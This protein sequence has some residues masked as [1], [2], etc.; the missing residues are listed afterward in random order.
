MKIKKLTILSILTVALFTG[1]DKKEEINEN[2]VAPTAK[3]A[4]ETT[5]KSQLPTFHLTTTTGKPITIEVTKKNWV[6]KEYP[7]KVILLNF[8]ATWCPP[9]KAE[10]PHLNNLQT[11]YNNDFQV[12]SILVEQDKP[13]SEANKFIKD[14]KIIYPI[15]NSKENFKLANAVGGVSSI[16]A[17]FMFN[18]QGF[19]VQNYVGAVHEEVL[20]SDIKKAMKH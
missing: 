10:I 1:C 7:N 14:N 20:E 3:V 9:C 15:T 18:K 13:N 6:F 17:M 4:Q 12:I 5:K 11:K 16:P 19:V 2:I 8:F